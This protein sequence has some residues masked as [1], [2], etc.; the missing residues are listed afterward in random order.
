MKDPNSGA[1]CILLSTDLSPRCDRAFERAIL[2]ARAWSR[3]LVI[4]CALEL[5]EDDGVIERHEA[6]AR[7]EAELRRDLDGAG[8]TY[9]IVV[10]PGPPAELAIEEARRRGCRLLVAGVA[11]NEILG[12]FRAG[13][14]TQTMLSHSPAP[15]LVV[16]D[17]VHG[18]YRNLVISSD[19]S[20]ASQVA[21]ERA[22]ALFP[23]A[24]LTLLHS[25]HVP[26]SGFIDEQSHRDDF[27]RQARSDVATFLEKLDPALAASGRIEPLVEFGD[28]G[29]TL[30]EVVMERHAD[31]VVLSMDRRPAWLDQLLGSRA[32]QLLMETPCDVM[33]IR[34]P[35]APAR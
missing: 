8:I 5:D 24:K 2:L 9:E 15:V 30:Q 11:R 12:R 23:D 20:D 1:G 4:V 35:L 26:F 13:H 25:Y 29:V 32:E 3:T 31:L 7:V 17:R 6:I 22:G 18:Q 19:F 21:V 28:A 10:Q 16:K 34:E 27:L 14:N 33:V